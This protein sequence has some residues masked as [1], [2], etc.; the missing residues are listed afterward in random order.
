VGRYFH[1]DVD[2]VEVAAIDAVDLEASVL[3]RAWG[4]RRE[5]VRAPLRPCSRPH[6]GGTIL[7]D[8]FDGACILCARSAVAGKQATEPEWAVMLEACG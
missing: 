2:S 6:C 4:W 8:W 3:A 5:T 7:V 1:R